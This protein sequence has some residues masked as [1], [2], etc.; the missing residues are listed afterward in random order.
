VTDEVDVIMFIGSAGYWPQGR[1]ASR[2]TLPPQV[3]TGGAPCPGA[4]A[5]GAGVLTGG[6]RRRAT[7]T[8]PNRWFPSMSTTTWPACGRDLP[9]DSADHEGR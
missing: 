1:H 5:H 7:V 6:Q 4:C 8:G 3:K 2:P 9:C